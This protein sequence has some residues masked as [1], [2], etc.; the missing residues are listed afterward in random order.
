VSIL[1]SHLSVEIAVIDI[2][3]SNVYLYGDNQGYVE[4]LY[5]VY[6]GTHPCLNHQPHFLL[7]I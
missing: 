6:D 4:R 1:S 3:T 5:L 7:T 2:E